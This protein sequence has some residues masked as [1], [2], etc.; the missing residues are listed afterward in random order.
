MIDDETYGDDSEPRRRLEY[1]CH[2]YV[3]A[4]SCSHALWH[5]GNQERTNAIVA[6][7]PTEAWVTIS[8]GGGSGGPVR[9]GVHPHPL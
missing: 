5:V 9:L 6:A 7:L 3:L 8:A 1:D 2:P 4:V